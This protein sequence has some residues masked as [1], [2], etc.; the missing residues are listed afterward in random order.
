MKRHRDI[1][2]VERSLDCFAGR[3]EALPPALLR[4]PL[5]AA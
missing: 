3:R 1:A 5:E 4:Q 2:E